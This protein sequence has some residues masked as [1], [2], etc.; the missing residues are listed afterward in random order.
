MD[1]S[2]AIVSWLEQLIEEGRAPLASCPEEFRES[3][4]AYGAVVDGDSVRL[5]NN[6]RCLTPKDINSA[7]ASGLSS[8]WQI[9][10]HPVV[11]STN[12]TL[13][14][15]AEKASIARSL[16]TADLQVSGKGRR[17]RQWV[18]PIGYGVAISLG[19]EPKL[20]AHKL[21]GLS[22]V[23]GVSVVTALQAQ[24]VPDVTLKWPNDVLRGGAKL[25][26]I[27][28]EVARTDPLRVVIGIG[29]NVGNESLATPVVD[30][31]TSDLTSHPDLTRAQLLG[32]LLDELAGDLASFEKGGF[33]CFRDEW[34]SLH[35][36][37]GKSV[38]LYQADQQIHGVVRGVGLDGQ[39]E[40]ATE[41]GLREFVAGEV[42]LRQ[43]QAP[44]Q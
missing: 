43:R 8:S 35:E 1:E 17:G 37:Q 39:L 14:H 33:A 27:L 16:L 30:Q 40:L 34:E 5:A 41:S 6:F 26:G 3:I 21:M 9:Q 44:R 12:T 31:V 29:I 15:R 32:G 20:P 18:S 42:S 7:A 2:S 28:V 11:A 22:L 13:M 10:C 4:A 19:Y 38:T 36:Y 23:V 25:A 24:N